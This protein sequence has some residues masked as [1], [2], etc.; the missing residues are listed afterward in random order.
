MGKLD[1]TAV[2]AYNV[3][4]HF[5]SLC[6]SMGGEEEGREKAKLANATNEREGRHKLVA[7]TQTVRFG[8]LYLLGQV[9]GASV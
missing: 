6:F 9:A 5:D 3:A 1:R 8:V 7:V 2:V 4:N